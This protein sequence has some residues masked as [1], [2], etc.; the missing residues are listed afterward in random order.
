M[1]VNTAPWRSNVDATGPSPKGFRITTTVVNRFV[2]AVACVALSVVT[3]GAARAHGPV[4][5]RVRW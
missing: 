3:V 2:V 1:S 5:A 4:A